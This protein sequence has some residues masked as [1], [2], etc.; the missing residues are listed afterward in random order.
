MFSLLAEAQELERN[1]K[2]ILA[3][4]PGYITL[5]GDFHMHTVFSDGHVWPTFRVR[6]AENDGLDI[7]ALTEH[8]GNS[9]VSHDYDV[10]H[11][12][13][14]KDISYDI[15]KTQ[16]KNQVLII[17][18]AEISPGVPPFHNNAIFIQKADDIPIDYL[19]MGDKY[20]MKKNATREE[21]MAP[22]LEVKRQGGFVFYNHPMHLRQFYNWEKAENKD[23]FTDFHKELLEMGI[24]GGVEVV[25]GGRYNSM[26]HRIAEK[27]RLTMFADSDA[28]HDIGF[29]D[30][31][32]P[33]TL[34]FAKSKT[35]E[36][37][38]DAILNGRTMIYHKDFLI[39]RIREA[40]PFF[41]SAIKLEAKMDK[42]KNMPILKVKIL[43][44]TDVPYKITFHSDYIVQNLP[45]QRTTLIP[46]DN[47]EIMIGPLWDKPKEI[48]LEIEIQSILVSPDNSLKTEFKIPVPTK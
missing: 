48:N 39:G 15:A 44:K 16:P 29:K 45:M 17:K 4:I 47:T 36:A 18:G 40:E 37:V 41:K 6:E 46:H 14:K 7:I 20:V 32:R 21:L 43:N 33:M 5:K 28:H 2:I 24:L 10:D 30:S 9:R 26:A 35:E 11:D 34:V 13:I 1:D 22:F 12:V 27:Y 42:Y 19:E 23:V 8:T 3:D 38:K 31:H 25:N